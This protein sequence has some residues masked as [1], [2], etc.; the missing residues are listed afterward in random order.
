MYWRLVMAQATDIVQKLLDI[1][2]IQQVLVKYTIAIDTQNFDLLETCFTD[3]AELHLA[4]L[5][6][7]TPKSYRNICQQNLPMLNATQHHCGIPAIDFVGEV[8]HSR[9]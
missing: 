4:G 1:H 2:N 8:A 7:L 9:C 5:G 3:D 6:T